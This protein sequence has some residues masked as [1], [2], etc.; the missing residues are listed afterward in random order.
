MVMCPLLNK[1]YFLWPIISLL[2]FTSTSFFNWGYACKDLERDTQLQNHS[3]PLVGLN[4][5]RGAPYCIQKS[6][7]PSSRKNPISCEDLKGVGSLNTTCL[8]NSSLY[9]A[10]DQ[11][12]YGTGN[13]LI[14]DHVTIECPVKGCTLTF[15]VTGNITVCQHAKISAGSIVVNATN[16]TLEKYS[17]ISTTALGGPPPA[18]TSGTPIGHDGAGGGHGGRGAS[19][20][21]SNQTNIWGGDVYAWSNLSEPWSYG[22]KGGTTFEEEPYGGDGGG[23]IMLKLTDLIHVDGSITAE[24]GEGGLKGG[25]G[26]G[27]SIIIA[28]IRLRGN[29]I[30][31]AAGG[32]G[33]GGGGGGRISLDCYS[34]Q[35]VKIVVHGGESIGCPGNS[36]AAGTAYDKALLSLRVSNENITTLTETPLLDFPT[37]PLWSNVYVENN[38]KALVPLLWTR[39]QVRGQI[40]V[41][42]GGSITFGLSDYPVSEFE[43]VAEELLMRDSM[44]KVYG[45]LRMYVKMLLMWNAKIL[46]NGGDHD[47]V[48]TSLLEARNLVVLRQNS[49]ISSNANLGVSG[50]GLLKLSGHGDAIKGQRLFLSLFYNIAV[51]TGSVL[52]APLDN[53]LDSS[54]ATSSCC[55]SQKCPEELI[56]PPEDCHFNNSLSFTLQICRVEDLTV[57][58]LVKGSIIHIH[59][60]RTVIINADGMISA[61]ELGCRD[62]VGKGNFSKHGAG[63]GAGHGGKGGTGIYNGLVSQGGLQYGDADLPC[64]LGSGNGGSNEFS[65]NVAGGGMIVMGSLKW[66][67]SR[68]EIYGSLKADGQSYREPKINSNGTLVGGLGGGSGGTILLFLQ[69]LVLGDNSSLTITGGSG[70]PVGGGGGGGGR[71]HLHWSNIATGDEYVQIA[72]INGSINT[73]GGL[74]SNGGQHGGEGTIT[75]KKCPKGLYGTFCSECPVGTYKDVDGSDPSLCTPCSFEKLPHRASFVYVRGGVNQSSCPYRCLSDKYKMPNCYTP[76]EE[77]IYTFGGPWPFALLLLITLVVLSLLLSALRIKLVESDLGYHAANPIGHPHHHSFPSLLSLAEVPGTSRAEETQSHVHRMYFMG[78]NTFREPWHLPYSPPDAIIAIVYEDAFNRFIDEINSVAAYEWW[79]GS[80]HSILSVLA[81]PC[82]WSWKQWCRR[83]KIHRL[84]EYVKSEYDHAC[85]RSCRSRA[86]YKGMKVGSTPDLV[87]AYIDFFLGGDE[88]RLDV[89]S[90]TLQRFPMCVII[91]GDG[92]YMSPYNL[93]SDVL[94]TNLLGQYVPTTK[95]SRFVAGLNAQLRTV[96][97]GNIRSALLPVISWISTHGNAQFEIHGIRIELGW[98]QVTASGY[99]QLGILIAANDNVHGQTDMAESSYSDLPRKNFAVARKSIKRLQQTQLYPSHSVSR[100]RITG[101]VNGGIINDATLKSLDYR[102]DFLYPLSLFLHN[103]RPIGFQDTV[104]L[105]ICIMLLSDFAVTFLTFLQFYWISVGDFLAILFILPLSSLCPFPAGLNALFSREPRR[106]S[107]ARIYAL[108]NATSISNIVVAF[109]CGVLH[110][111]LLSSKI[112]AR[113]NLQNLR[114]EDGEWWVLP[115]IL[116]IIKTLQA[117][118]VDWHI[119]NLEVQDPNVYSEDPEKFWEQ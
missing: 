77:L 48:N 114:R 78:P 112:S 49:I 50:Q 36:G 86:L 105:F 92:S 34:K 75:G 74:G 53:K 80:V 68:L 94:L 52:Q 30:I 46:I 91:G 66:P 103:T 70:G 119:A 35:D 110:Y 69:V 84:Q 5:E 102:K 41:L 54:L 101:G 89:A 31:S 47:E 29:G 113:D 85:L 82:A 11:N 19:C 88:K 12:I 8:L 118:L 117:R 72:T 76:L 2:L 10:E 25:G 87:V 108:W 37:R 73:S 65:D 60:S 23:R 98:F 96:R 51:G 42:D 93:H 83:K 39:V 115:T 55:G 100:K 15:K 33:W 3:R 14:S 97:Q 95:W 18:Q 56:M 38:A 26:S 67:L 20:L 1:G 24:G 28:A 59:R 79:E 22:S 62:G 58:G 4:R 13:L 57:N 6:S 7:T 106:S 104:Q 40:S 71:V 81:C 44:L 16:L 109:A 9:F 17:S 111:G 99:Y 21:R 63:G 43:L 27:G 90:G 107:L 32:R 116:A 64:E 61:S 45:A